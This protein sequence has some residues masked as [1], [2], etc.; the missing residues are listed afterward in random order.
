M[1]GDGEQSGDFTYVDGVVEANIRAAYAPVSGEVF[2][3]AGG[4]RYSLNQLIETLREICDKRD[5][6]GTYIFPRPGYIKD[7]HADV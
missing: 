6:D 2:N 5:C 1:Y 3:V 4:N 7:S